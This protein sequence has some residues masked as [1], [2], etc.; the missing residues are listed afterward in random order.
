M[1]DFTTLSFPVTVENNRGDVCVLVEMYNS[2]IYGHAVSNADGYVTI[3]RWN[4]AGEC[5]DGYGKVASWDH[6]YALREPKPAHVAA[7]EEFSPAIRELI[8]LSTY[9]GKKITAIKAIRGL[10]KL[11]LTEAKNL[12]EWRVNQLRQPWPFGAV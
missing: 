1:F 2:I 11:G 12:F 3:V 10:S 7:W 9:S 5:L 4:A 6:D 8:D